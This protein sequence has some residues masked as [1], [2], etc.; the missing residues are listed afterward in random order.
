MKTS[1]LLLVLPLSL[2]SLAAC[3][4]ETEGIPPNIPVGS[5][6][7]V[8]V[9]QDTIPDKACFKIKLIKDSMNYDETAIVFGHAASVDYIPSEDAIYLTGFGKENLSSL[10]S[11]GTALAINRLPY[12]PGMSIYLDMHAKAD[13]NFFLETSYKNNI[14]ANIH[15][16][17]TD[18][19]LKDSVEIGAANYNFSVRKAD[20]NSMG[21][22]R[23][24]LTLK[25]ISQ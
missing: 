8:A 3:Q 23:F 20:T 9:S 4:K 24:K 2:F 16:W 19:F 11:D 5:A 6:A 25:N 12:S 17:L 7:I 13:G 15:I 21:G 22:K 18:T 1:T 14:P 10:S